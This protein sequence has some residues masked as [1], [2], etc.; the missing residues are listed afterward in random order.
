VWPDDRIGWAENP[1][2]KRKKHVF[3]VITA[4]SRAAARFLQTA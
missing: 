3:L 2:F 4:F 1:I